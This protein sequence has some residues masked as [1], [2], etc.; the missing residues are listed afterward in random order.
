M[1]HDG[2][3]VAAAAPPPGIPPH[4]CQWRNMGKFVQTI[5][6]TIIPVLHVTHIQRVSWV[7]FRWLY[8][9]TVLL[10]KPRRICN[11]R[12]LSV[13][14]SVCL[15]ATLRKNFRTDLHE[16][17]RDGWQWA[18]EQMVKF[19]WR[20]GSRIRI[21]IRIATLARCALAEVCLSQCF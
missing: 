13:C 12:C 6:F 18:N 4:R 19:W 1:C 7:T 17:F 21:Q 8:T 3:S 9:N 5:H 20:S 15:L 2:R 10:L 11:R 16:I 14:L